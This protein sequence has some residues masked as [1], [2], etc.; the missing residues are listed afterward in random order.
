[1]KR[2]PIKP[3]RWN[4]IR[5]HTRRRDI[6]F[7]ARSL[8]TLL[9][10]YANKDGQCCFPS[11]DTLLRDTGW[12]ENTFYRHRRTLL[13]AGWII[14]RPRLSHKGRASTEYTLFWCAGIT[15]KFE[16]TLP[17]KIAD[18]DVYG[19]TYLKEDAVNASNVVSFTLTEEPP[20]PKAKG[21]A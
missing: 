3:T 14:T 11:V 4:I 1:M 2:K 18:R 5:E 20:S 15:A 17:A 9:A 8:F 13:K 7:E 21:E 12:S 10:T 19:T 16:D 6:P